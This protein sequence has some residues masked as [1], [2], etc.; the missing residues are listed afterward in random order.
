LI[1]HSEEV[2][3]FAQ[4]PYNQ[5]QIEEIARTITDSGAWITPT[6]TT[7]RN[8]IA[9][10]EDYDLELARPE[11]RYLHPMDHG[12][13]SF[14][15]TNLYQPIPQDQRTA[16]RDGYLQFQRPLTRALS[17]AGARLMTGTDALIPSNV[18]GFSIHDELAE[19]VD[20]G[21]SPYEALRSS[22]T[23][24][25]AY[26]DELDQAGTIAVGKRADLVLLQNNPL[27]DISATR[28]ISGVLIQGRW[29]A[30]DDLD[31]G[32][33]ALA[34]GYQ[35]RTYDSSGGNDEVTPSSHLGDKCF[36]PRSGVRYIAWGV[37]PRIPA[38]IIITSRGAATDVR[39]GGPRLTPQPII[40][41]PSGAFF[42]LS[43]LPWGSRPRLNIFRA[44]GAPFMIQRPTHD[45]S[46][47][48]EKKPQA[49]T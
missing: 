18:P 49:V 4:R 36:E 41:R 44:S 13:W 1:A 15:Y 14:I 34:V 42:Y 7:S 27:S 46:G 32:L 12:I 48:V 30:K 24:P 47:D 29:L 22:T 39:A 8:I 21:L 19:L 23:E 45:F 11:I 35:R 37:S 9:V 28:G 2:M 5:D 6:L 31:Q 10:L 40:C 17:K 43:S 25:F 26:L 3:K 20:V 38:P 33:E 16:I